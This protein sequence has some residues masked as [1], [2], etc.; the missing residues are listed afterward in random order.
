M[1]L[2]HIKEQKTHNTP[3]PPPP[4]P[5]T[6]LHHPSDLLLE[7][8][9]PTSWCFVSSIRAEARRRSAKDPPPAWG[10]RARGRSGTPRVNGGSEETPN[11]SSLLG[12][13]SEPFPVPR[14]PQ[15]ANRSTRMNHLEIDCFFSS[16]S[17][18]LADDVLPKMIQCARRRE[19]LE[20]HKC[21]DYE[22]P[23][24]AR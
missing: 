21:E 22:E 11:S 16:S 18:L 7:D 3:P 8:Q 19:A 4:P 17:F 23:A 15:S 14:A 5:S 20:F 6:T 12:F 2:P 13:L 9:K 1:F 24:A 10:T